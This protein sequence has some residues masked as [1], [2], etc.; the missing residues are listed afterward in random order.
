MKFQDEAR[1]YIRS[2][3]GGNGCIGFRREKFIEYG[4][5]NGGDGGDGGSV[6]AECS[7]NL[8]TLIDYKFKQHF[9]AKNGEH[10]KGSLCTGGDGNDIILKLPRGTQIFAD[11]GETLLADLTH[12]G[13]KVLLLKG[14]NGGF[15]NARFKTSTNR[16]PRHANDGQPSLEAHIHL[17]L[18]LIADVGIIGLPNAG[19]STFLSVVTNARPKIAAYP[20]TTLYPNLGVASID[21]YEF[22][23]ADIPGLIEGASEGRGLGDRFLGHIERCSVLLH[24]I[25][26]TSE[27]VLESYDVVRN[28]LEQYSSDLANKVEIIALNKKDS[29]S[30]EDFAAKAELLEEM[31]DSKVFP[32]SSVARTGLQKVLRQLKDIIIHHKGESSLVNVEPT[33]IILNEQQLKFGCIAPFTIDK[34][35][36]YFDSMVE[37]DDDENDIDDFDDEDS[38]EKDFA[39]EEEDGVQV[40][41]VQP[42]GSKV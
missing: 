15:G 11:D 10:G 37:N 16:A 28:E 31:T 21:D 3:A 12:K 9:K 30:D 29:V 35:Q 25:D 38:T 40:I 20:F 34:M 17:K 23:L 8:N 18:K 6:Y 1:I 36:T 24:L 33:S 14:G 26:A 32:L 7:D 27:D 2:G 19:K 39:Y 42:K 13:Q 22:I 4:G 41:Y 5:P